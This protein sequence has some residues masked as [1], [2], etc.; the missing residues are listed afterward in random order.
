MLLFVVMARLS[1]ATRNRIKKR[2]FFFFF[3]R[4]R[5]EVGFGCDVLVGY[6]AHC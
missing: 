3:L 5:K 4:E 2:I 6:V 1:L